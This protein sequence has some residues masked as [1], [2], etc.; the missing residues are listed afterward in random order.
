MSLWRLILNN[1]LYSRI[2]NYLEEKISNKIIKNMLHGFDK[3]GFYANH[4]YEKTKLQI[5]QTNYFRT[6]IIRPKNKV[7]QNMGK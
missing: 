4:Y 7:M 5:K 3:K 6:S 2:I 1:S